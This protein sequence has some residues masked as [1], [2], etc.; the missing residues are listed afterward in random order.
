MLIFAALKKLDCQGNV[1]TIHLTKERIHHSPQRNGDAGLRQTLEH[2][3]HV[4]LEG[5]LVSCHLVE[6]VELFH[7][8]VMNADFLQA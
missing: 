3:L 5:L 7:P 2:L 4:L 6:L 8:P 1:S